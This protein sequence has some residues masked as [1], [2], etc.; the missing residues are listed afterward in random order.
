MRISKLE[1]RGEVSKLTLTREEMDN[2]CHLANNL[3][4]LEEYRRTHNLGE[5]F[6][7]FQSGLYHKIAS[8]TIPLANDVAYFQIRTT[9]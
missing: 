9:R 7:S 3:R 2:L 6:S 4:D 1:P 8:L 5:S